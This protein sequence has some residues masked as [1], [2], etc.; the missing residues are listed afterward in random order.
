LEEVQQ[1]FILHFHDFVSGGRLSSRQST[2]P[3]YRKV[4]APDLVIVRVENQAA[5]L[6]RA[7][8]EAVEET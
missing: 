2:V 4:G 6:W 3:H 5:I 8:N 1:A 7:G